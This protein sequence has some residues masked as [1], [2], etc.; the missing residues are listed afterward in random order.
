MLDAL[1]ALGDLMR[2]HGALTLLSVTGLFV[3]AL[4]AV[5]AAGRWRD[6]A[7]RKEEAPP[8]PSSPPPPPAG[9]EK[10]EP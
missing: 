10:R 6:R 4:V 7:R 9:S 2:A 3:L 1:D 5:A 8:S